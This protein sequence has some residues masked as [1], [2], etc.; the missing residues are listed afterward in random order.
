MC[1]GVKASS[2][3]SSISAKLHEEH[4][5]L[6]PAKKARLEFSDLPGDEVTSRDVAVSGTIG[7]F[8]LQ[9]LL[10]LLSVSLALRNAA[11]LQTLRTYERAFLRL[12]ETRHSAD[13]DLRTSH[14]ADLQA[15]DR[16][17]QYEV[18]L[19]SKLCARSAL[20]AVSRSLY[21]SL[22]LVFLSICY[23]PALRAPVKGT[24]RFRG[25]RE[26]LSG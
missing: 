26:R 13:S 4:H 11:H 3:I 15:A 18:M 21:S 25:V 6:R 10:S 1:A 2:K 23:C 9:Q 17:F 8:H 12:A 7:N 19:C 5:S 16:Q 20:S 22:A 24:V 14:V